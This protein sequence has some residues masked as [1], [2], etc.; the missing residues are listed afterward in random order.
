MGM[1]KY[2]VGA[3]KAVARWAAQVSEHCVEGFFIVHV[4]EQMKGCS[5]V[6]S[7]LSNNYSPQVACKRLL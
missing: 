5:E 4:H 7:L 3:K 2:L 1:I 6:A